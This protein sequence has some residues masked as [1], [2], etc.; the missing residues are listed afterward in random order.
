MT[1]YLDDILFLGGPNSDECI[2]DLSVFQE[3]CASL[4][5]P[6]ALDKP[7]GPAPVLEFLGIIFDTSRMVLILPDHK[8]HELQELIE[9][10]IK[11]K[12]ATKRELQLLAGKFQHTTKVI[13]QGRC[14]T[15]TLYEL[16]ALREKPHDRI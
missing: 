15:R 9:D 14:F 1:H 13:R 4:G 5:V 2:V 8:R 16:S 3:V 11:R 10:L 7:Q 12:S 6:L